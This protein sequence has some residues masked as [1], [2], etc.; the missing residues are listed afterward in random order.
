MFNSNFEVR[1]IESL[2]KYKTISYESSVY[3]FRYTKAV[4]SF[5]LVSSRKE[6]SYTT[7]ISL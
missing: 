4:R 1:G 5:S 7:K 3:T 2:R 6:Q